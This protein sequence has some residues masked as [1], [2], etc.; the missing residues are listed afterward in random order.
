METRPST[1]LVYDEVVY[2]FPHLNQWSTKGLQAF[3]ESGLLTDLIEV[4]KK[5]VFLSNSLYKHHE[6]AGMLLE[7][8]VIGRVTLAQFKRLLDA[9]PM[10]TRKQL[11]VFIRVFKEWSFTACWWNNNT[12]AWD[13]RDVWREKMGL[14]RLNPVLKNLESGI[15][16]TFKKLGKQDIKNYPLQ[17]YRYATLEEASQVGVPEEK[18]LHALVC[19]VYGWFLFGVG[20]VD[21]Y[22]RSV[23]S[24]GFVANYNRAVNQHAQAYV[25]LVKL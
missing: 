20:V 14:D 10:E 1:P 12:M 4:A 13:V 11:M 2:F 3:I 7:S 15:E 19:C 18:R 5:G 16:V 21:E 24:D 8:N 25:A 23:F 6:E 17:G 9:V 22:A